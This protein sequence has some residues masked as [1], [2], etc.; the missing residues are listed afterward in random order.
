MKTEGENGRVNVEKLDVEVKHLRKEVEN[1]KVMLKGLLQV[2][3]ENEEE[4]DY[5]E[6]T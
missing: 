4:D 3:M 5:Y 6:Y 1:M 2:V